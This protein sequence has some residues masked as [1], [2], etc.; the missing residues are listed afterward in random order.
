MDPQ[1]MRCEMLRQCYLNSLKKLVSAIK[2]HGKSAIKTRVVS[3]QSFKAGAAWEGHW[4]SCIACY[5][6]WKLHESLLI[7][8]SGTS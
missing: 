7:R 2:A 4:H 8:K 3:E 6:K 1:C 5:K